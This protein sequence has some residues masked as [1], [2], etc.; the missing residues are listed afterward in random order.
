[1]AL[2]TQGGPNWVRNFVDAPIIV[3]ADKHEYYRQPSFYALAHFSKFLPPKSFR[4]DTPIVN[5]NNNNCLVGAF[6]T[7]NAYLQ[8]STVI[9]VVNT[10]DIEIDF[11]AE[12]EKEGKLITKIGP[13]SIQ[14][15]VY[16][17]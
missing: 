3:D 10:E 12:D 16:Y 1:M 15:Y 17:D 7:T 11:I 2:D 8:D 9:I 14:T 13:K 6:R 4:I 5:R